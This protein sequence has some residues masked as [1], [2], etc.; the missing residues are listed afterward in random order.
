VEQVVVPVSSTRAHYKEALLEGDF[1]GV[2]SLVAARELARCLII[3]RRFARHPVAEATQSVRKSPSHTRVRVAR[4][5]NRACI[6]HP[7]RLVRDAGRL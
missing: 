6:T 2:L 3:R 7:S 5:L 4:T 1:P